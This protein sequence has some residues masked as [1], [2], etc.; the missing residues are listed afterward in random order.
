MLVGT[1]GGKVTLMGRDC[2][3]NLTVSASSSF[4]STLASASFYKDAI[5]SQALIGDCNW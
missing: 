3:E 5:S 1:L 4:P 2:L